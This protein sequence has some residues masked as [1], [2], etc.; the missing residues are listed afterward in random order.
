MKHSPMLFGRSARSMP[1][2]PAATKS[3][4]TKTAKVTDKNGY[5]DASRSARPNSSA[6]SALVNESTTES[7]DAAPYKMNS[8]LLIFT[9]ICPLVFIAWPRPFRI[10]KAL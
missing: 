5:G 1:S 2:Q 3:S 10:G 8:T 4:G 7:K 6:A 9:R